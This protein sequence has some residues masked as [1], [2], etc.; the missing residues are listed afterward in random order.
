MRPLKPS[1]GTVAVACVL[2]AASLAGLSYATATRTWIVLTRIVDGRSYAVRS[3][4]GRISV[5]RITVAGRSAPYQGGWAI[6]YPDGTFDDLA[7]IPNDRSFRNGFG[8]E[9]YGNVFPYFCEPL[10]FWRAA[11]PYWV[12]IAIVLLQPT[13]FVLRTLIG[14]RRRGRIARGEC[15][16][17]GYDIRA[18][19]DHCPECGAKAMRAVP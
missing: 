6:H 11:V 7:V 9:W 1:R 5:E 17:C 15:P 19:P 13:V 18:T 3:D 2:V 4:A 16:Q 10:A 8:F 14:W 12:V